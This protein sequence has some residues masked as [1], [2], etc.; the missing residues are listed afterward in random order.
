[1]LYNC[2]Y[3]NKT[4]KLDINQIIKL[5]KKIDTPMFCSKNCSGYYYAKQQNKNMTVEQ[6]KLKNEKIRQALLG[7][8][9]KDT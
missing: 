2:D 1:M 8:N 5:R 3:C 4:F 9:N 7:K 6:K